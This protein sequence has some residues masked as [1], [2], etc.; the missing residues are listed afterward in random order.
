MGKKRTLTE[1]D[2]NNEL[3]GKKVKHEETDTFVWGEL[4][5]L[6]TSI[7]SKDIANDNLTDPE[8]SN[9]TTNVKY[10]YIAKQN[11]SQ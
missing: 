9:V 2:D 8:S 4:D 11:N 1:I 3:I 5:S 7:L 10:V 6:L